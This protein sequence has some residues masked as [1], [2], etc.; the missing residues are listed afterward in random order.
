MRDDR[1]VRGVRRR[2]AGH[3]INTCRCGAALSR[4][5][6]MGPHTPRIVQETCDRCRPPHEKTP[7]RVD[8]NQ[9]T[10][11]EKAITEAMRAVEAAGASPA[12]TDAI[13]LLQKARDRVADHADAV[14]AER[15]LVVPS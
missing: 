1:G 7:R 3:G 12:L 6:C 4:C 13:V 15:S 11:A 5:R 2:A 14:V 9:H 8:V 10:P